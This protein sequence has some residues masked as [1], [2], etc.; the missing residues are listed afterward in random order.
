[1]ASMDISS[2]I[3]SSF[4]ELVGPVSL[5]LVCGLIFFASWFVG[6]IGGRKQKINVKKEKPSTETVQKPA[7]QIRSKM[8]W[9]QERVWEEDPSLLSDAPWVVHKVTKLC[10]H[11]VTEALRL[12]RAARENG[13]KLQDLP[14]AECHNFFM[15]LVTATIREQ[16]Y[17]V[18]DTLELLSDLRKSGHGVNNSLFVSIV[19][20]CTSRQ[21]YNEAVNIFDFMCEDS[22]FLLTDKAGWSCLL[23]CSLEIK[24]LSV[25]E[26][27]AYDKCQMFFTNL[28]ACGS[29]SAKD[30]SNMMKIT[31]LYGD[32]R[33][34]LSLM[35][36]M[37]KADVAI[38]SMQYNTSFAACVAAGQVDEAR[39]LLDAAE[40]V[41]CVAD[42]ITYNTIMKGYAKS[43]RISE[44]FD[45]F[46]RMR[47]KGLSSSQVTYGI[48]LDCCINENQ[49]DRAMQVFDE[50]ILAGCQM[51][52]VLCTTVIKGFTRAGKLEQAM[53]MYTSMKTK[54]GI[55]PDIITFS[56][57]IKA[58][59]DSSCLEKALSLLE[60]M[61][62]LG[63]KPDEVV[64]N[65]LMAG[66]ARNG[67][68]E[69]GK[70]LYEDMVKSGVRPS[71]ATYSILIRLFHHC[72]VLDEAVK[73]IT[74][75]TK[76]QGFHPEP[77][78]FQQ[79]IQSCIR[80]RQGNRAVQ[81]YKTFFD[82]TTP[83]ASTSSDII[84]KC[85]KLNM[86]ETCTE[87]IAIAAEKGARIDARDILSV[88]E[89]AAKKSK[90]QVVR[91]CVASMKAMGH[92][93]DLQ[94]Y[95]HLLGD[96]A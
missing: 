67:N 40:S 14:A 94:K 57:L 43:G 58:N 29:P 24:T 34:G 41:D 33:G 47:E 89:P 82:Y 81:V 66:C 8:N 7:R 18:K 96:D 28:K 15:A 42:V 64:F 71:C 22:T 80:E 35:N 13:F 78:L 65:N 10:N 83:C 54:Y 2:S 49:L 17:K 86:L 75:E 84:S 76:R 11:Q 32:W 27:N 74:E 55:T 31:S 59:C 91:G 37:R 90:S 79:L 30:F 21:L 44:C 63:L 26:I 61:V 1:M 73:L 39:A 5:E 85:V 45:M 48:L 19:K 6:I 62:I 12:Y 53:N 38:D 4:W 60:D 87:I 25:Q 20:L 46:N 92:N 36:E 9:S 50:M 95:A 52:I 51:N 23:F 77:R 56:I 93:P 72:K 16:N 70:Q 3:T 88:I 68:L 69:L